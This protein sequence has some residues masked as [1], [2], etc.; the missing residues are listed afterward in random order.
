MTGDE[1]KLKVEV[2]QAGYSFADV[3]EKTKKELYTMLFEKI[4]LD[5]ESMINIL[6]GGEV[7]LK[8]FLLY[9]GATAED[10]TNKSREELEEMF[11]N[12]FGLDEIIKAREEI[13]QQESVSGKKRNHRYENVL[14]AMRLNR[15]KTIIESEEYKSLKTK[16]EKTDFLSSLS[17]TELEDA[18]IYYTNKQNAQRIAEDTMSIIF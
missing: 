6:C 2:M 12:K 14:S 17:I 18:E 10:I 3:E 15:G 4:T 7:Q 13:K 16:E 1:N 5:S 11:I 9:F 8:Q